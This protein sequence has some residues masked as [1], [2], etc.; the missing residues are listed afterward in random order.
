MP[1]VYLPSV[2]IDPSSIHLYHSLIFSISDFHFLYDG[3]RM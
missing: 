1:T 2:D 3:R